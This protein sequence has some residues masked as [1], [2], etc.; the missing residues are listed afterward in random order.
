MIAEATRATRKIS[1]IYGLADA[2]IKAGLPYG[3]EEGRTL[4]PAA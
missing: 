2:L 4:P 3:S 1:L